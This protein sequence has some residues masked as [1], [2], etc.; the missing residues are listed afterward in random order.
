MADV[1]FDDRTQAGRLLGQRLCELGLGPAG[2]RSGPPSAGGLVLGL[3][4]GGV[5]VAV[6]AAAELAAPVEVFVARK[7]GHPYQPEL[8]LGAIAEGGQA[9]WDE[10]A[11]R[12]LR[13][14]PVDL[15]DVVAAEQRELSRRVAAYRGDRDLPRLAGRTVV[16]VDD[17][18]ATGGTARAAL[19][20][21]R[22]RAPAWLVFAAPVGPADAAERLSAE[23]DDVVLLATPRPFSA[24]GRFYRA[25]GQVGDD[26]VVRLLSAARGRRWR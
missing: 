11:L 17:G 12:H 25:F 10:A 1:P 5:V 19:R 8:G 13:L 16:L 21:L 24:V 9:L 2:E 20:A 7:L 3:P 26:E 14:S 22:G 23:A 6:A 4:R 18:V 15:A